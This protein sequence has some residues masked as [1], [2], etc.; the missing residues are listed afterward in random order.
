[1]TKKKI[2][3][4]GSGPTG[5]SV[6]YLMK[7]EKDWEITLIEKSS[8]VGGLSGSFKWKRHI[9]DYGPHRLSPNI[10]QIVNLVKKLIGNDLI[11]GISDHGVQ[12][13]GKVFNFPVKI[14][15]WMN[16]NSILWILK[17]ITSLIFNFF[18]FLFKRN[19]NFSE[20]LKKRFGE[21]FYKEILEG[22]T[23]KVWI[24][25]KKIDPIFADERFSLIKPFEILKS[26]FLKSSIR[27][28]NIFY[29][30]INGYQQIWDSMKNSCQNTSSKIF[31]NSEFISCKI[32]NNKIEKIKW[33][34]FKSNKIIEKYAL[35][36]RILS[37]IPISIFCNGIVSNDKNLNLLA[38]RSKQ[39]KIRSMILFSVE[40]K[41]DRTLPNRT[42]IF[43][44]KDFI[45]NRLFEQNLYSRK[46]VEKNYSVIV[47]DITCDPKD[48]IYDFSDKKI[49]DI[50]LDDFKK[51]SYINLTKINSWKVVRVPFAYM[52]PDINSRYILKDIIYKLSNIENLDL[53]GRFSI[54]EY[55]NSDYAIQNAIDYKKHLKSH[56]YKTSNFKLNNKREI[57]G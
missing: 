31:L 25:P 29:Y 13:N 16:V 23:K 51:L 44:S 27:N 45:F 12:L 55:D 28:P 11:E 6:A 50:V 48:E 38:E 3:I 43:P 21:F 17:V 10:K 40:F 42:L 15:Q 19:L 26:L 7:N 56:K 33:K 46:T 18:K 47:A 5:L 53:L 1:M 24:D 39:I 36:S 34:D 32:K 14:L 35:N 54:G 9:V 2:T 22:M 49:A 30:P 37:T 20:I 57:V 52:V 4:I 8:K 41:Q